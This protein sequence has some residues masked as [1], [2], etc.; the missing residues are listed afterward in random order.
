VLLLLLHGGKCWPGESEQSAATASNCSDNMNWLFDHHMTRAE[1]VLFG[2]KKIA[3]SQ[4]GVQC[5]FLS[6]VQ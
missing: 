1:A 3:Q 6:C 2:Y 4:Q 5:K